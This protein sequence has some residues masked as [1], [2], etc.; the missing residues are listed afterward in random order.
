V[1]L[2]AATATGVALGTRFPAAPAWIA[3][4]CCLAAAC[5]WTTH[6]L[7]RRAEAAGT[8]AD[9]G[10]PVGAAAPARPGAWA[11]NGVSAGLL[12][13]GLLL[14][15]GGAAASVRAAAVRG[16]VLVGWVGR[17]GRVE[18]AGAVAEE[19]RRLRYGGRW[20]V[21][22][23]DRVRLGG[24]TQ[25][26]RERAGVVL[27]AAAGRNGSGSGTGCGCG[28]RWPRRDGAMRWGGSRRWCC[29]IP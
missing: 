16:G 25:T 23:V 2:A 5:L 8:P 12:V 11:G 6:P 14:V 13:L 7:R 17:P 4:A 29:G 21:L 10:G 20:V 15:A 3:A 24:R 19:P 1:A 22:T 9:G 18:V 26:T 27:G 28:G